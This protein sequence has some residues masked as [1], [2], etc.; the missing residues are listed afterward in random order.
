MKRKRKRECEKAG[1][2]KEQNG[3]NENES[4]SK[5]E[6]VNIFNFPT[7]FSVLLSVTVL[8]QQESTA[9]KYQPK[10]GTTNCKFG[11]HQCSRKIQKSHLKFWQYNLASLLQCSSSCHQAARFLLLS[12]SAYSSVARYTEAKYNSKSL[13]R[14]AYVV[15]K[16]ATKLVKYNL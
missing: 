4:E 3:K 5:N 13:T 10:I 9:Q 16:S 6:S 7:I 2:Q 15:M 8:Q 14:M 11:A 1:K 12:W